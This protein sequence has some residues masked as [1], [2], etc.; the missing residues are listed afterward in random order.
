M[1]EQS[2]RELEDAPVPK[3]AAELERCILVSREALLETLGRFEPD[4]FETGKA[5]SWSPKDHVA[6]LIAWERMIVATA[7]DRSATRFP[8]LE[9][10]AYG[11]LDLDELNEMLFE[12]NATTPWAKVLRGF[13][14]TQVE[15]RALLGALSD[16]ALL[17]AWDPG[18]DRPV[19]QRIAGDTYL[20]YLEHRR[21]LDES[22]G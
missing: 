5:G 17:T 3:T 20:H 10:K 11:G 13:D 2:L 15:T 12:R 7:Q 18:D 14:D 16:E 6:H 8:G 1:D 9:P 21:W 22:L 4:G 19:G